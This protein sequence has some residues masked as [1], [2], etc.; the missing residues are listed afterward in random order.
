LSVSDDTR[1]SILSGGAECQCNEQYQKRSKDSD[2]EKAGLS[3]FSIM[4]L[5][6]TEKARD[7]GEG[8]NNSMRRKTFNEACEHPG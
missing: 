7:N 6:L 8:D 4:G 1:V 2:P 3:F 5:N